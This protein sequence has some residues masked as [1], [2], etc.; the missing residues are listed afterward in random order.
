MLEGFRFQMV[1]R[2]VLT[3]LHY[4][5]VWLCLFLFH[6]YSL[7]TTPGHVIC[8]SG[9]AATWCLSERGR[10]VEAPIEGLE[11]VDIRYRMCVSFKI[12]R[13]SVAFGG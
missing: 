11:T 7:P 5:L 1:A 8:A 4:L 3:A 9:Y 2:R 12:P 13:Y 6:G 10:R